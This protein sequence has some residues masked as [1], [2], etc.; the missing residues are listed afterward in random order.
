M[1]PILKKFFDV[2]DNTFFMVPLI[3][4]NF[5]DRLYFV[6]LQNIYDLTNC[7]SNWYSN[8]QSKADCWRA[9]VY[10]EVTRRVWE[11]KPWKIISSNSG[12]ANSI[13]IDVIVDG[14]SL[15]WLLIKD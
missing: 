13:A 15:L 12:K 5:D 4:F 7:T 14:K 9:S 2:S 3:Y 6:F 8:F 1:Y 10:E 11:W